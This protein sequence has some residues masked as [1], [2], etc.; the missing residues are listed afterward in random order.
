MR[1]FRL[2]STDIDWSRREIDKAR[3]KARDKVFLR[4]ALQSFSDGGPARLR[5][6]TPDRR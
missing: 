6:A 5:G 4:P 2:E 1:H 3:D